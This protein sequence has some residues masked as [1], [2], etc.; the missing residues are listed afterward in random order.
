MGPSPDKPLATRAVHV[1]C[2]QPINTANPSLRESA[3]PHDEAS[4]SHDH[5]E[6]GEPLTTAPMG[7]CSTT[8][9]SMSQKSTAQLPYNCCTS[10]YGYGRG[11]VAGLQ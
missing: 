7:S 9:L 3:A 8:E 5:P 10:M 4:S 6:H 2:W 11:T 1:V